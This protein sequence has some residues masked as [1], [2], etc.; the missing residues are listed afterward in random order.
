MKVYCDYCGNHI[1]ATAE[2]CPHCGAVNTHFARTASDTPQTIDELKAY[3]EANNL[4][5]ERMH[6]HLGEDYKAPKAFGIY[7]D[8]GTGHFVV[9]KNKAN[10]QRAVRYEGTDEAYAVNEIYLKIKD[11]VMDARQATSGNYRSSS[12]PQQT[13]SKGSNLVSVI[14]T[15][16]IIIII[17]AVIINGLGRSIFGKKNGYYEIDG[18]TY[19]RHGNYWYAYDADDNSWD[20]TSN[21][22]SY[23]EDDSFLGRNYDDDYDAEEFPREEFSGDWATNDDWSGDNDNSWDDS[24]DSYDYDSGGDWDSDW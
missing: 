17:M 9:Y 7:K 20:S 13:K 15:I 6:V 5:L 23:V 8:Q 10:G 16:S 22:D 2:E 14:L 12:R 1:E 24:Y 21:M 19:Y 18:D 3:C 4:P 11:L